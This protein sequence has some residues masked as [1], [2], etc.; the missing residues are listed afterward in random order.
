MSVIDN[1]DVGG[2]Y[3]GQEVVCPECITDPEE[4]EITEENIIREAD[5]DTEEKG[6]FCDRCKKGL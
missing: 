6:Y 4:T 1:E 2:Y 5:I 3:V